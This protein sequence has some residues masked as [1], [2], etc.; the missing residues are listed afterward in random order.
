MEAF[1]FEVSS[2]LLVLSSMYRSMYMLRDFKGAGPLFLFWQ[3]KEREKE[4]KKEDTFLY[5]GIVDRKTKMELANPPP[6]S[7]YLL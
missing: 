6:L 4:R 2:W 7:N 3:E 1:G 5:V